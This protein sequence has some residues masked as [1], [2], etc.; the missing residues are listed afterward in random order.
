VAGRRV[1]AHEYAERVNAAAALVDDGAA[2]ADAARVLAAR[3]D[4]SQRQARRYVDRA[5][6]GGPVPVRVTTVFTVKL[7][8]DLV[9]QVRD[10]ARASGKTISAVVTQA[11]QDFMSRGAGRRSGG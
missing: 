5:V 4:L 1:G 9:R 8:V 6:H 3:F 11:V 7:P 10:Y 2:V